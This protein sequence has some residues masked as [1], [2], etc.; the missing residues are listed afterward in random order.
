MWLTLLREKPMASTRRAANAQVPLSDWPGEDRRRWDKGFATDNP[1]D[2]TGRGANLA[3]GTVRSLQAAHGRYLG[4]LGKRCPEMLKK[5]T[6]QRVNPENLKHYIATLSVTRS[7]RGVA[8]ELHFLRLAIKVMCPDADWKWLHGIEKRV[9]RGDSRRKPALNVASHELY[10]LGAGLMEAIDRQ[11]GL[12]G[13]LSQSDA[14]KFR[15]GLIIALL[16]AVPIRRRTLAALQLDHNVVKRGDQWVLDISPEDMKGRRGFDLVI[17]DA[18]SR[19]I[20]FYLAAVRPRLPGANKH[21]GLW[22]SAKRRPMDAGTIYDAVKRR[23]RE[24]LGFGVNLHSFRKASGNLWVQHDPANVRALKDLLGH[25]S[26]EVTE[27]Y[28]IA[29]QTR[30]AGRALRAVIEKLKCQK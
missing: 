26:F 5:P 30:I 15:D 20:D 16:A 14:R 6:D 13:L 3:R 22:A 27:T 24:A 4:F 18:L 7:A 8:I 11:R 21:L 1:F 17:P 28:Y 19:Q 9:R 25:A 2:A 12:D 10:T 29:G 23:T